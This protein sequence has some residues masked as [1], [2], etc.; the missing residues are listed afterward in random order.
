M[1]DLEL[2]SIHQFHKSEV[3]EAPDILP[4]EAQEYNSETDYDR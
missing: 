1:N 4:Q 2:P 3:T